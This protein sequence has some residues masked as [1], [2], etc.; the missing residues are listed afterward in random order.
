[1]T[2]TFICAHLCIRD[3]PDAV[4]SSGVSTS[5]YFPLSKIHHLPGETSEEAVE[6]TLKF[7]VKPETKFTIER[8]TVGVYFT[9]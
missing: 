5:L 1:V 3:D 8:V 9:L 7:F 2:T 4:Y 6:R